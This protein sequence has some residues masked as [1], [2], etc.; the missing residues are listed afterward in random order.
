[1]Q[2]FSDGSAII[3]TEE[4][5]VRAAAADNTRMAGMS[6]RRVSVFAALAIALIGCAVFAAGRIERD[7]AVDA[8][9]NSR[10]AQGLLSAV[11]EQESG[12]RG[13]FIGRQKQFLAP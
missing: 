8:G 5:Q 4:A 10:S 6:V 13:F 3:L 1:M 7:T 11:R 9:R 2:P 12:A